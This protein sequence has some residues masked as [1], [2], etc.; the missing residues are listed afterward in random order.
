MGF[1]PLFLKWLLFILFLIIITRHACNNEPLFFVIGTGHYGN[2]TKG[3]L[4]SVE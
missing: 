4:L 2:K 3:I 1:I